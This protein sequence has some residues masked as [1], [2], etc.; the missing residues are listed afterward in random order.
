MRK[1]FLLVGWEA[2]QIYNCCYY[3]T[4]HGYRSK[5][6]PLFLQVL[7]YNFLRATKKGPLGPFWAEAFGPELF[8]HSAQVLAQFFLRR[9]KNEQINISIP[10]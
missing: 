10:V 8:A 2:I 7:L 4:A 1:E 6:T 5:I 3:A 9:K